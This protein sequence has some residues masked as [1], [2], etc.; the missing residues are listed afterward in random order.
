M[1]SVRVT[2]SRRF[3]ACALACLGAGFGVACFDT[4][5]QAQGDE[6]P[7]VTTTLD[8][9][10][11]A[12]AAQFHRVLAIELGTSIDY[13]AH[14]PTGTSLTWVHLSCTAQGIE[15]RLDDGLTRKSMTRVLD[16]SRIEP[17][18]RTRL[19]ALAVAEFVVASWVELRVVDKPAVEPVGP[20][21]SARAKT[22]VERTVERKLVAAEER[23]A[24]HSAWDI[25]GLFRLE[26]YA[27][28]SSM[29]P[30]LA[31]RFGQRP[32][33][34]FAFALGADFGLTRVD[35]ST[36]QVEIA[37]MSAMAAALF[38]SRAGSVDL[39][40]GGGGRF[41]AMHMNGVPSDTAVKGESFYAPYGG[42]LIL[43]RAAFHV[44]RTFRLVAEAEAGLVTLPIVG[45]AGTRKVIELD[46]AWASLGL[47]VGWSF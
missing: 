21:P 16:I 26:G 39:Y 30:V 7:D 23:A 11:P 25:A 20:P 36:G 33:G 41:G 32:T 24:P 31:V 46:G 22:S 34:A 43:G 15:L 37:T 47:G 29:A 6:I 27:T 18:S 3:L 2:L 28:L 13:Q 5:A 38:V 45:F 17:A 19:L 14:A 10:V 40:A 42:P 9:C 44:T 35:V 8:P 4:A 1:R 12:D